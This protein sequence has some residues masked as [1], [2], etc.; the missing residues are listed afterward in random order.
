[1]SSCSSNESNANDDAIGCCAPAAATVSSAGNCCGSS[2]DNLPAQSTSL[3]RLLFTGVTGWLQANRMLSIL[4]VGLLYLYLFEISQFRQSTLFIVE[5]A[6]ALSPFILTSILFV[7][8]LNACG[9][10]GYTARVF[11]ARTI[12]MIF[13]ASAFGALSPLCSCGVIPVILGLLAAGVPLAPVIAFWI[14]SPIMDPEMFI[15]L[16]GGIGV[17]FAIAKTV[18]AFGMGISSGFV[19]HLLTSRGGLQQPLNAAAIQSLQRGS[20]LA[21]ETLLKWRF[22]QQPERVSDFNRTFI[23]AFKLIGISLCF[24]FFLESLMVAYVPASTVADFVRGDSIASIFKA[25]VIG[26][27]IYL[28]G[29]AAIPLVDRL[30][31]YGMLPGVAMAFMIGGSVTSIPAVIAVAAITRRAIFIWYLIAALVSTLLLS[32][33]YQALLTLTQNS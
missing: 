27:P 26:I 2:S 25:I 5:S 8:S 14:A 20:D 9:I 13:L 33:S 18:I 22:W 17:D 15:L 29:Y 11:K 23:G 6:L 12:P 19:T 16:S 21:D 10:E 4:I 7:A 30:M 28:N 31:D 24:A 3:L 1:M 32:Y